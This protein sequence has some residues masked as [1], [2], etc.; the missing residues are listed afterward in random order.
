MATFI[1]DKERPAP[2][3]DLKDNDYQLAE[4]SAPVLSMCTGSLVKR[5]MSSTSASHFCLDGAAPWANTMPTASG[6]CVRGPMID[7]HCHILCG[8]DDGA[9][10]LTVSLAMARMFAADGVTTVACTPHIL[11]GLYHNTGPQIRAAIQ[12]LQ[13]E[14]AQVDI[15]LQLLTGADVHIAPDF[16]A[17][18]QS[19]R[20]L[21]LA[22]SRYVLVEPPHHIAPVRLDQIFFDLIVAGYVPILTHPE[23]LKWIDGHYALIQRLAASGVWM[24]ITAGSLAGTFGRSAQY[25]SERMLDEGIVHILATDAHDTARRPPDLSR[26]RDLA[27]KRIG[28]VEAEHLVL[29]RPRGV[30]ENVDPSTLQA[31]IGADAAGSAQRLE[32]WQ[33]GD[34]RVGSR[35]FSER[36][37][38]LFE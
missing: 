19:G 33:H 24:Q 4:I 8:V 13:L 28:N 20:L 18:L 30:V 9:K 21:T 15:P 17:G 27:A 37:R 22:D 11:P 32:N 34:R 3:K 16:V 23:R 6:V 26:G 31:P 14:L 1:A 36:L 7:L 12:A 38:S 2:L 25:W 35:S 5:R 29:T 10:D